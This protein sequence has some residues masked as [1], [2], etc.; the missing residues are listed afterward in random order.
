MCQLD[1]TS[2]VIARR[3]RSLPSTTKS[4]TD[5]IRSEGRG[6]AKQHGIDLEQPPRFLIG[7]AAHHHAVDMA[8]LLLRLLEAGDAAI[9]HDLEIGVRA[10]EAVHNAVIERRHIAVFARRQATEP[11]LSRMHDQRVGASGLHSSRER[12]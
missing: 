4:S 6:V 7:G 11:R 8:Q 1:R 12:E 10:L 9:E 2:R 3:P 5:G